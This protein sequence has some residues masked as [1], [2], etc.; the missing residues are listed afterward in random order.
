[1]VSLTVVTWPSNCNLSKPHFCTT[2]IYHLLSFQL[3][4]SQPQLFFDTTDITNSLIYEFGALVLAELDLIRIVVWPSK[5][6]KTR[7]PKKIEK[8]MKESEHVWSWD[9]RLRKKGH[10]VT[11]GSK[12]MIGIIDWW[13]Q[14]DQR[15]VPVCLTVCLP[16]FPSL[17]QMSSCLLRDNVPTIFSPFHCCYFFF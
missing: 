11:E 15:I 6:S 10:P 13:F 17:A 4:P 14:W 16:H 7:G 5:C 9:S 2:K 1:M 8:C 3:P 12:K